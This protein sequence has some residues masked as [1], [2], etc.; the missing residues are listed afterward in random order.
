MLIARTLVFLLLLSSALFFAV[1]AATGQARYRRL[2]LVI[3]KWTVIAGLVFFA[4]IFITR[5]M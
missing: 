4:V 3:L 1:Y 5:L 2:G